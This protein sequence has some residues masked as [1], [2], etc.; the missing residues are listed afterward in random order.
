MAPVGRLQTAP[1]DA[2]KLAAYAAAFRVETA[3]G[4]TGVHNMSVDWPDVAML[5][6]LAAIGQGPLQVYN[7]IDAGEAGPLFEGGPRASA[8]GRITT[9]AVEIPMPRWRGRI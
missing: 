2:N 5:E 7:A 4:W 1:N 3:Y 6:G 8:D 9:R